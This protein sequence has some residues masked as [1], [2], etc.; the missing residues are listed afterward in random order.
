MGR[1][2]GK[3]AVIGGAGT[4]VGRAC[5]V[6]FAKEGANVVGGARTQANL[7]ETLSLVQAEDGKGAVVAADLSTEDGVEALF[8]TAIDTYGGVDILVN[9]AGLGWSYGEMKP[10]SMDPVETTSLEDWNTV[11]GINLGSVFLCSKAAIPEMRKRGGGSIVNLSSIAGSRS[12][13]DAHAYV[14]GKGAVNSLTRGLA[15]AYA[16]D[17]IRTNTVSPGF[18]DTPMVASVMGAFDDPVVAN[19]LSPMGRAS[20][21]EEIAYCCLFFASDESSYCNGAY[22]EADG[23]SGAR[24]FALPP[25]PEE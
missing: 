17:G 14:A 7:D 13:I 2:D 15:H 21:P 4:G 6:L 8:S 9:S 11:L 25:E 24:M 5:M 22:L 20:Q 19:L 23:G 3:V 1:L 10:G 18:I 12:L 16:S